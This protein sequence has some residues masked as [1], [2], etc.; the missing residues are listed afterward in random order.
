MK[1]QN[2]SSEFTSVPEHLN[3]DD[4]CVQKEYRKIRND[5]TFSYGNKFYLIESPLRH[6]IAKQKIEI[7]KQSGNHFT[8][9][10]AGRH[11]AVSEVIEPTK[12]SMFDLEI[13]K[14]IDA[15]ELAEK[16]GN[17]SEAARISGC[18][19]ETIYKNRRL[20]KEKGPLA[21]KRTYRPDIHHK[22]RTAKDIEDVVISFSLENPHL[23][24]V[25]VSAQ[26][27]VNHQVEISPSGV[28]NIWLRADMQ[29]MALRLQQAN[30]T[31]SDTC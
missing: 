1:A 9:Y 21:L 31:N 26:L 10:F 16:L 13:Q 24:Q 2:S 29:T 3:L 15:I 6:S 14:K 7:R 25:Q 27:K 23:G 20:L 11:L 18:S 8:A 28:R 5:H 19:R 22:N 30:L 4:I 17:V 12:P